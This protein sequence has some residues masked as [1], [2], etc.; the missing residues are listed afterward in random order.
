[1][2]VA[3]NYERLFAAIPA[4]YS[5][6]KSNYTINIFHTD[7]ESTLFTAGFFNKGIGFS[8]RL[9]VIIVMAVL[10]LTNAMGSAGATFDALAA[11]HPFG[12]QIEKHRP[13]NPGSTLADVDDINN[14][15]ATNDYNPMAGPA[16][17]GTL[18]ANPMRVPDRTRIHAEWGHSCH[19]IKRKVIRC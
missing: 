15:D 19:V 16:S 7:E 11:C 3:N 1:M 10:N 17:F 13:S 2:G 14:Y 9:T 18:P 4:I 5:G 8:I 12:R 6:V